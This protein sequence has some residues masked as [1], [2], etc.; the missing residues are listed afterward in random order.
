MDPILLDDIL[1]WRENFSIWA[2]YVKVIQWNTK[3]ESAEERKL[4]AVLAPLQILRHAS[5]DLLL[6]RE[7]TKKDGP[8]YTSLGYPIL[9]FR[10]RQATDEKDKIYAFIGLSGRGGS[11]IPNYNV[12]KS[13]V[14]IPMTRI[15]YREALRYI[16]AV[17]CRTREVKIGGDLPSW[18]PDFN[19]TQ[20]S[21]PLFKLRVV[22]AGG[23]CADLD[24][25][26]LPYLGREP[27]LEQGNTDPNLIIRGIQVGF[28]T[29]VFDVE[30]PRN[31]WLDTNTVRLLQYT[32]NHIPLLR[33]HTRSADEH[34]LLNHRE[35]S[36]ENHGFSS[37]SRGSSQEAAQHSPQ[38]TDSSV[39]SMLNTS[40]APCHTQ[41]G[42]IIIDTPGCD[43]P[44]VLRKDGDVYLFVGGVWLI[45]SEM[46]VPKI[47][48]VYKFEIKDN[49]GFS[50]FMYGAACAGK[51]LED[52]QIFTLC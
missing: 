20:D 2:I 36:S 26:T 4:Q 38:P 42:D 43:I 7:K 9:L 40:W 3:E 33:S 10:D 11:L 44:L 37:Q 25:P 23:F 46:I 52:V 17:E 35:S 5:R 29:A 24:F 16:L 34:S 14:Y 51:T 8:I 41:I 50:R 30:L 22:E 49:P 28:V 6:F 45:D 31:F 39:I 27:Y 12:S 13:D 32:T 1:A 18:V 48:V 15:I 21:V 47:G 19:L